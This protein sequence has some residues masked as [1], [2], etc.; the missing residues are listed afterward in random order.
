MRL[1]DID[2][3]AGKGYGLFETL[4][5]YANGATL[6]N[7]IQSGAMRHH[8]HAAIEFTKIL[9]QS[10]F[11]LPAKIAIEMTKFVEDCLPQSDVG[12]QVRRV[13]ERFALIAVAGE[14]ASKSGITGWQIGESTSAVRHCF[15]EWLEARGSNQN[16]EPAAILEAVRSFISQHE[17]SRFTNLD[18]DISTI[19]R[20]INNRAGWI[21]TEN[22]LTEYRFDPSVFKNEVCCGF[23]LK[24]VCRVLADANCLDSAIEGGVRRYSLIRS[25][26]AGKSP[27]F[28]NVNSNIMEPKTAWD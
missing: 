6:S 12:G 28:Y 9:A 27:R 3:D 14:L 16:S 25:N 2:A 7:A 1:V 26:G 4:H 10:A 24:T 15:M 22:Q 8:G 18:R 19:L 17:E 23:D 21:K 5:D 20:T 13:C 11:E